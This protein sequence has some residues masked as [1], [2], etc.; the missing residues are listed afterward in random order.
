MEAIDAAVAAVAIEPIRETSRRTLMRAYLAEGNT[1]KALREL[2]TFRSLLRRELDV[3]PSPDIVR[4]VR[5]ET[6]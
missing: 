2:E 5:P 1:A 4:M 3:E 6:R